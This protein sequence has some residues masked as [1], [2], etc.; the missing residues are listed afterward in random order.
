V[1]ALPADVKLEGIKAEFKDGVLEI[2]LPKEKTS[3]EVNDRNSISSTPRVR[4]G[5]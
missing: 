2:R 4:G 3:R 5:L 1:V